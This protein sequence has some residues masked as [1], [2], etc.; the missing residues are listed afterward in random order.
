MRGSTPVQSFKTPLKKDDVKTL[1]VTYVQDGVVVIKKKRVD[2]E[3]QDYKITFRLTQEETLMFNDKNM[4]EI[5]VKMK[6]TSD[7][8]HISN[9]IRRSAKRVLD[10]DVI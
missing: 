7:I 6:D 5:Q 1:S 8:L 9:I 2:V 10:E 3:V 4:I